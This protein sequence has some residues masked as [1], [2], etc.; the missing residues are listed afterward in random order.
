M[1]FINNFG[2]NPQVPSFENVYQDI[3]GT[4]HHWRNATRIWHPLTEQQFGNRFNVGDKVNM[5]LRYPNTNR[6]S[7]VATILVIIPYETAKQVLGSYN[8]DD[9][10]GGAPFTHVLVLAVNT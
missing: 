6:Q 3:S 10:F 9:S 5:Q 8:I 4:S 2:V 7:S 1:N